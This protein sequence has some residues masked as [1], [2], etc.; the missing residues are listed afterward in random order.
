[1]TTENIKTATEVIS[2]FLE[3]QVTDG[4]LDAET[5]IAVSTLWNGDDL[6]K[7]KLLRKLEDARSA[8]L[9]AGVSSSEEVNY[10]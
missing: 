4:S 9:K 6:S 3:I 8:A 10:D 2:D 5:V 1:L 7:V